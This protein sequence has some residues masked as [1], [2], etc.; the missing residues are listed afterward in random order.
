M[1]LPNIQKV[2]IS[3][4]TIATDLARKEK[5]VGIAKVVM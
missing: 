1:Y 3:T 5:S 2:P 4:P